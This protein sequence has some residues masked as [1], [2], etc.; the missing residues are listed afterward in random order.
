MG[1][2]RHHYMSIFRTLRLLR[3][4]AGDVI[5]LGAIVDNPV[6]ADLFRECGY[7]VKAGDG[8]FIQPNEA[9]QRAG[10]GRLLFLDVSDFEGAA[11]VHDLNK[12]LPPAM[13]GIASVVVDTGTIEHVFNPI[14]A[15][16]NVC[17]MLQTGGVAFLYPPAN[18]YVDHGFWQL[19]PTLLFD[20]FYDNHFRILWCAVVSSEWEIDDKRAF[21]YRTVQFHSDQTYLRRS[22]PRALTFFAAQKMPESTT[23]E[24]PIQ[25]FYA[26]RHRPRLVRDYQEIAFDIREVLPFLKLQQP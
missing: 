7:N 3:H 26:V 15:T 18:G 4:V 19:S 20:F 14:Q 13:R 6:A 24:T 8:R 1:L 22:F 21:D 10:L 11:L 17:D 23:D 16:L 5:S 2:G 12:P 9:F 25:S